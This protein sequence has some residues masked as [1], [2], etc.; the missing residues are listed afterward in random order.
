M[1]EMDLP[2]CQA[3]LSFH[4]P[5]SEKKKRKVRPLLELKRQQESNFRRGSRKNISFLF[6]LELPW[7][8]ELPLLLPPSFLPPTLHTSLLSS[9]FCFFFPPPHPPL[10]PSLFSP[11]RQNS[12]RPRSPSLLRSSLPLFS[13]PSPSPP[14][15]ARPELSV[16]RPLPPPSLSLLSQRDGRRRILAVQIPSIYFPL[17]LSLAFL[18]PITDFYHSLPPSPPPA[19]ISLPPFPLLL[20]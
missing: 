11:S 2:C 4:R 15:P 5:A 7:R 1:R 20:S 13:L 16:V 9:S 12:C 6:L 14:G 17:P 3:L 19:L 18:L 8:F 10:H